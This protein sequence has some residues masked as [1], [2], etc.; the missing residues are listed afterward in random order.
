MPDVS[1]SPAAALAVREK[2]HLFELDLQNVASNRINKQ[3]TDTVPRLHDELAIATCAA[4]QNSQ[5][6]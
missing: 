4:S 2:L 6:F 5:A 3:L 1:Q